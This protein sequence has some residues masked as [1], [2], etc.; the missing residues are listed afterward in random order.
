[1]E[2]MINSYM[3]DLKNNKYDVGMMFYYSKLNIEYLY[4]NVS[5]SIYSMEYPNN[6]NFIATNIDNGDRISELRETS[7]IYQRMIKYRHNFKKE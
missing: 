6:N 5:S 2:C 3:Y 4:D 1:M 7:V